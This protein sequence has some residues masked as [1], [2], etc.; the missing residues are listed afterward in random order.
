MS[1]KLRNRITAIVL[2]FAF[3][4]LGSV[5]NVTWN[6]PLSFTGTMVFS[7]LCIIW[8]V[9]IQ[10]RITKRREKR[11]FTLLGAFMLLWMIERA[12]KFSLFLQ[13]EWLERQL[14]YGYYIPI[15]LM[16]LFS[17]MIALSVGKADSERLSPKLNLLYIP[18]ILLIAGFMTNDR[19]QLAFRFNP[20]FVNWSDDYSHG[21]LYY[22]AIVWVISLML[23]ALI[24]VVRF[25]TVNANRRLGMIPLAVIIV[26]LAGVAIYNFTDF[27]HTRILN[28]TELFCFCIAAFWES[29]LQTG[30]IPSNTGYDLL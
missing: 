30:L 21:V 26:S 10:S 1:I 20:N 7:S 4:V 19:H 28:V 18:E 16:P 27:R 23:A 3:F 8:T 25:S 15:L 6:E 17:L 13:S 22:I 29:C 14:W 12:V 2:L 5:A 24:I 9:S 11:Y